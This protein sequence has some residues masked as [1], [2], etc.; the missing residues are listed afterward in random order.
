MIDLHTHSEHSHDSVCPIEDMCKAQIAKGTKYW[1]V[2]DHCDGWFFTE[3]NVFEPIRRSYDTVQALKPKYADQ[4][5]LLSGV[6]ISEGFWYP[7]FGSVAEKL[8]DYDFI[9][10]SAHAVRFNGE[11]TPYSMVDFSQLDSAT[12]HAYLDTYFDEV[13]VMFDQSDFDVLAHLTC[14]LRYITGKYGHAVDMTRYADKMTAILRRTI[15]EGKALEVN[16][17]CYGSMGVW[18]PTADIIRQ[19]YELGGR[20][21]TV[22]SD[23][24]VTEHAASYIPQALAMLKEIG[25]EHVYYYKGRKPYSVGI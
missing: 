14:P 5:E 11:R 3:W 22:G 21:I 18:M 4:I 1:A 25:F 17:S 7:D 15:D 10:G 19:Y 6:E 13:Q 20:L 23:A 9:I 12:V 24:H 2:T 16:T 8:C